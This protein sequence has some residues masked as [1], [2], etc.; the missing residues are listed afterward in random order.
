MCITLDCRPR[1]S[2]VFLRIWL[3]ADS[4]SGTSR[5]DDTDGRCTTSFFMISSTCF[6]PRMTITARCLSM[7]S[8][9]RLSFSS[10]F[11]IFIRSPMSG[12]IASRR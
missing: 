10:S 8:T 9:L 6:F 5:M 3:N 12:V 1:T 4:N 11:P 7:S 2:P